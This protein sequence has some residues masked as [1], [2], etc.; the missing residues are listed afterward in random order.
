VAIFFSFILTLA[1]GS[2]L[3]PHSKTEISKKIKR[4]RRRRRRRRRGRRGKRGRRGRRG[5]RILQL[6]LLHMEFSYHAMFILQ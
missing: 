5:R 6:I 4:G 2:P 1:D 3:A